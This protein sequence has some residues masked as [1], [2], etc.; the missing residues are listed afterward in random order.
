MTM[1][2]R[3]FR[4]HHTCGKDNLIRLAFHYHRE[5]K[6]PDSDPVVQV[7][8]HGYIIGWAMVWL[9]RICM[10][11]KLTDLATYQPNYILD[12]L[13]IDRELALAEGQKWF[14]EDFGDRLDCKLRPNTLR[15]ILKERA[16]VRNKTLTLRCCEN[17]EGEQ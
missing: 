15:L 4:N 13:G 9:A 11:R 5:Y 1:D 12:D 7:S 14:W 2:R 10:R 8:R 6:N 17:R 16:N 3:R